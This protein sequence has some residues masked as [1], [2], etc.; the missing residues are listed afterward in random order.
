MVQAADRKPLLVRFAERVLL[1]CTLRSKTLHI[2]QVPLQSSRD[3]PPP[4]QKQYSSANIASTA[5]GQE[6][7]AMNLER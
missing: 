7:L 5:R 6:Q 3:L 1:R 2:L 4:G